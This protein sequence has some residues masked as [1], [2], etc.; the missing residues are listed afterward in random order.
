VKIV[1]FFIAVLP[2]WAGTV[3]DPTG[4][5]QPPSPPCLTC[6]ESAAAIPPIESLPVSG[7]A[8][9]LPEAGRQF[10]P[11]PPFSSALRAVPH[12]LPPPPSGQAV[13]A[14]YPLDGLQLS[15]WPGAAPPVAI[16]VAMVSPPVREPDPDTGVLVLIGIG[17][18]LIGMRGRPRWE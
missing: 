17:L 13:D 1:A 12:D 4:G 3:N 10:A 11:D 14:A 18:I 6:Q 15:G 5:H 8:V 16:P 7:G 9:T 2:V